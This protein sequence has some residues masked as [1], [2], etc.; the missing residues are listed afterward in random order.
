MFSTILQSALSPIIRWAKRIGDLDGLSIFHDS[1]MVI[2]WI[3]LESHWTA[4]EAKCSL[5]TCGAHQQSLDWSASECAE[6][7]VPGPPA[8][9]GRQREWGKRPRSQSLVAYQFQDKVAQLRQQ[10]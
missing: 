5:A 4:E 3:I 10:K 9:Q 8:I 2:E 7:G 1:R 6:R